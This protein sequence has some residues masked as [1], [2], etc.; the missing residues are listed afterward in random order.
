MDYQH[1]NSSLG[2]L[3]SYRLGQPGKGKTLEGMISQLPKEWQ[4][5]IEAILGILH[6]TLM[7]Q[8]A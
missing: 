3:G 7:R 4:E 6:F 1:A 2:S 5:K 8:Q